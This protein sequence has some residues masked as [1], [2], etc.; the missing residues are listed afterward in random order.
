M[1]NKNANSLFGADINEFTQFTD[2]PVLAKTIDFLY[3]RSSGSGSGKFRVDKKFLDFAKKA[4]QYGIPVG[5]YHYALPSADLTDADR[6]ADDFA[7]ILQQGFG[8]KDY[9]DLFPVVDVEAPLD[10]S[11][12]TATLLNWVDRFR[13][14]FESNTRRKLMLYTGSFFIDMYDNFKHPTKG[15]ILSNMPLWIAMY[16]EKAGNPPYPKD[17]GGWTRWRVWQYTE[18]GAIKG[19]SSPTDLNWG[20]DSIDFLRPPMNVKGLRGVQ[21]GNK[22]YVTWTA[23]KDKDLSGYNLFLNGNYAGTAKKT[24]T[25]FTIDRNKV[26][27][28]SGT[29]PEVQIEAFDL[30]GDFSP[31]RTKAAVIMGREEI[32]QQDGMRDN[33]NLADKEDI[34]GLYYVYPDIFIRVKKEDMEK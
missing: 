1:Q 29:K 34:R 8:D 5:A 20:P 10:K 11:I 31:K 27:L 30:D 21:I 17:Q 4:R 7:K 9:G 6:Q 22:I 2:F 26:K 24:A 3:L 19:A 23:N 16:T 14:R 13:R 25:T 33:E 15:F 32:E 28:P 12:S 18:K